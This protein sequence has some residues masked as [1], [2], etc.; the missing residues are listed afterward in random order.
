VALIVDLS[1][2]D[3]PTERLRRGHDFWRSLRRENGLPHRKDMNPS[4]IPEL[5]PWINLV[6]VV[7]Q[8]DSRRYRHRLLGTE[9]V[10]YFR[11]DVTGMWFDE[12]Y[13]PVHLKQQLPAYD[14]AA[15]DAVPNI[16]S[17]SIAVNRD[18]HHHDL[19]YWRL[20]L[21]MT[22][23][24]KRADLLFLLFDVVTD[25]PLYQDRLPLHLD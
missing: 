21:P 6:D 11:A 10:N 17:V 9:L 4:E 7:W 23:D 18:E 14:R 13:T 24:D 22:M 15:I 2:D 16:D 3:L 19:V 8:G 25:D 20:I 5:L 1:A 12:V